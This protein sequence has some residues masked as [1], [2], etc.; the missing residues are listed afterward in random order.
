MEAVKKYVINSVEAREAD[1]SLP[2]TLMTEYEMPAPVEVLNG[3]CS[4]NEEELADFIS[5]R[6]L[7][8]DL[9]DIKLCQQY[10]K[11]E[12]RE[13]TIT[14]IKMIDLSLIHI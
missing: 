11:G 6:G 4:F 14:E 10:F 8:M 9:A 12:D 2:K 7:A 1:M 3:F 13:P 5:D